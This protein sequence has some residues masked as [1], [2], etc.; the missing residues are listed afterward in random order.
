MVSEEAEQFKGS[1]ELSRNTQA[2]EIEIPNVKFVFR[3]A[4]YINDL[5]STVIDGSGYI[6]HFPSAWRAPSVMMKSVLW[7]S[8]ATMAST[9]HQSLTNQ[10]ADGRASL[11]FWPDDIIHSFNR[12][13]ILYASRGKSL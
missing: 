13:I 6:H 9:Q 5:A 11:Y 3:E 8:I 10:I 2:Y 7:E 12:I 1:V 4:S